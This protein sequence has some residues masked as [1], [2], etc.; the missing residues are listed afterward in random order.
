[1]NYANIKY[2]DIANGPGVRTSLFVSGC[3][4]RCE[5]CFNSEAWAF[6]AGQPFTDEV[7]GQIIASCEPG[8]ITGLSLLGGEPMEPENQEAVL[9]LVKAFRERLPQKSIWCYS[10]YTFEELT[11]QKPSRAATPTALR[12]LE[13]MDVLVD[14]EFIEAQRDITLRFRGSLNQRILDLPASLREGRAV[15]WHDDPAYVHGK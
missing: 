12:L 5:G 10:G 8:W 2:C 15:D 7:I 13:Q 3:T 9:A 4:H 14:G 1:M 11:G 6:D